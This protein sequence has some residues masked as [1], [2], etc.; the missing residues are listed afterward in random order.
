M[1][2]NTNKKKAYHHGDLRA[3]LVQTAREIVESKGP[4]EVTL[5]GVAEAAGVSRAA[6]YHHFADKQT[7]LAAISAQGFRELANSMTAK[8]HPTDPPR[9]QLDQL[10]Y[11]YIKY[12][13]THPDLFR[14]M[15]GADFQ[16]S[17]VYP[18]LDE[19]RGQSA[20]PLFDA[21]TACLP[22]K[23]NAEIMTACA[24]A[25]SIVHGMT[26]LS[27]D[28]RLQTLIPI[29]DL[30]STAKSITQQLTLLRL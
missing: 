2:K 30:E 8:I 10:G 13:L 14:L 6:P 17:G 23:S 28:G 19:A 29:D 12:G 3:V 25:W 20:A 11:G 18:D 21:V 9:T 27:N 5:R 15:Q 4:S 26:M 22:G 1:P 16:I 24:A 7:L